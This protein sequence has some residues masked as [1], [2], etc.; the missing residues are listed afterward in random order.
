MNLFKQV[1]RVMIRC[2]LLTNGSYG[3]E[4]IVHVHKE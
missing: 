4:E 2:S 3:E 1:S